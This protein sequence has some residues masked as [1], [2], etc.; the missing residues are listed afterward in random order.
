MYVHSK[1]PFA[2]TKLDDYLCVCYC[3]DKVCIENNIRNPEE[4]YFPSEQLNTTRGNLR[5]T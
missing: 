3:E 4:L 2:C 5:H 1:L